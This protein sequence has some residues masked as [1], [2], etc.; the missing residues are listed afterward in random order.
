MCLDLATKKFKRKFA[1]FYKLVYYKICEFAVKIFPDLQ[2]LKKKFSQF[3]EKKNKKS[4]YFE[5]KS[6]YQKP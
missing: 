5:T 6:Q 3:C 2:N 1:N 4:N